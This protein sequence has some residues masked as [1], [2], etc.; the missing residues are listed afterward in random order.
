M[1]IL[2]EIGM[3]IWMLGYFVGYFCLIEVCAVSCYFFLEAFTLILEDSKIKPTFNRVEF[4]VI[5]IAFNVI[6]VCAI[7]YAKRLGWQKLQQKTPE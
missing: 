4:V 3:A 1:K 5:M 6:I 2:R 7:I